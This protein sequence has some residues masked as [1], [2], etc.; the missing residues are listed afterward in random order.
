LPPEELFQS[1]AG[2]LAALQRTHGAHRLT[3]HGARV[4]L[5]G[6]PNA[7]K[8]S[9]FNSL[10]G[11]PRALVSPQAGTTRDYLQAPLTLQGHLIELIDTAGLNPHAPAHSIEALGIEKSHDQLATADIVLFIYDG[12][13]PHVLP[14]ML[15]SRQEAQELICVANKSD[16][17]GFASSLPQGHIA[18]CA[19][20]ADGLSQLTSV[21][22]QKLNVLMPQADTL[23]VSQ[24]HA[25][26]LSEALVQ[27][28]SATNLLQQQ[29]EPAL[30]AHHLHSAL[31]HLGEI[32][33]KFDHEQI[34]DALFG[35]FCIG[36]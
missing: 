16:A 19:L 25:Q 7:G 14:E 32:L 9:L 18:A 30:I 23:M 24:R 31:A 8:S 33:G 10:L 6:A 12:T 17:P 3:F 27:L 22:I 1:L 5:L 21:L 4:V 20:T 36:K 35:E 11:H 29:A 2:A 34:L 15:A 28:T 26:A 13:Q